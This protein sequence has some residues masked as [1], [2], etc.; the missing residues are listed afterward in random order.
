[1]HLASLTVFLEDSFKFPHVLGLTEGLFVV[2][3]AEILDYFG[4]LA[5]QSI[6]LF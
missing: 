6:L 4:V 1:M 3:D 2:F 5:V